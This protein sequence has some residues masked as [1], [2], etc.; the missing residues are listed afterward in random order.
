M[1]DGANAWQ[2]FWQVTFPT[3]KPV[4]AVVTIL[5]TIWDF[6]VFAQVYLM[7]GG[8][9]ANREVLNLGTWSYVTGISQKQFGLG[10]TI[11]VL[12]TVLLLVVTAVYLRVLFKEDQDL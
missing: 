1:I 8:S 9:G 2:R 7:P 5:S 4:F 3:L 12:L 11:A 10:S 6:K